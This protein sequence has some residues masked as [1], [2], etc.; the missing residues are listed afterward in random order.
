MKYYL[1][2]IENKDAT[3]NKMM[4]LKYIM[5]NEDQWIP[6]DPVKDEF[7]TYDRG[8]TV[9]VYKNKVYQIYKDYVIIDK[10]L[11]IYVG[12]DFSFEN[13]KVE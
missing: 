5:A 3:N 4:G 7:N 13:D 8:T 6:I 11:R 2:P 9:L 10:Q 1:L 12:R